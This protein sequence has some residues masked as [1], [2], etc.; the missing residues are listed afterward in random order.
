MLYFWIL[1]GW[2]LFRADSLQEAFVYLG[3]MAGG[4]GVGIWQDNFEAL[5]LGNMIFVAIGIVG[6]TPILSK[7]EQKN[8]EKTWWNILYGMM[9]VVIF[10]L[11]VSEV[12]N[13]SYNPFIYFN[14]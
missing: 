13:T 12:I 2:V 1:I 14:F 8:K 9:T 7:L 3:A 11:A 6:S 4:N 10:I 5:P